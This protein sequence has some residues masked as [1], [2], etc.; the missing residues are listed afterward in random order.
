VADVRTALKGDD[1]DAIRS[2]ASELTSVLQR[3][4]TA[5]YQAAGPTGPSG[6]GQPGGEGEAGSA[7]G[8]AGEGEGAPAGAGTGGSGDETVEGEYKEV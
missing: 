5:A 1:M 6:D 3:V 8:G 4:A 2:R 7:E